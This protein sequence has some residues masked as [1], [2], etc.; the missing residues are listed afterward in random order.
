FWESR[1]ET[2]RKV[3]FES[4]ANLEQTE[5]NLKRKIDDETRKVFDW[6]PDLSGLSVLDLGA[7]VGQWSFRFAE[8]GARRVLAVEYAEGLVEIGRQEATQRNMNQVEFVASSAEQFR[9]D[10]QF[11][12]VYISGL[13]VY[14]NDEQL[15]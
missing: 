2:Y 12:L 7:G 4:I 9:T 15:E 6:L 10:E 3:A 11:D 13:C 1:A 5:D 14:L 8:R